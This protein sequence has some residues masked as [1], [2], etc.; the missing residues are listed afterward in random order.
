MNTG[1][2]LMRVAAMLAGCI[3]GVF[4]FTS[5]YVPFIL[6]G[7]CVVAGIMGYYVIVLDR[8]K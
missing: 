7:G 1:R 3:L 5:G 4:G 6:L 8:R 2:H